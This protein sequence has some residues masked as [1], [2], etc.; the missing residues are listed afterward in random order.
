MRDILAQAISRHQAG[1][2][3]AAARS[4]QKVLKAAP[5]HA[6]ARHLFGILRFQQGKAD[7]AIKHL[8]AALSARPDYPEALYNL[9]NI[10]SQLGRYAEAVEIY[11]RALAING[12]LVEAHANRGNALLE[13][14][15]YEEA[16]ASFDRALA[17]DAKMV[18]V[19][20]NRG[21]VLRLLKR[22]EEA[23]TSYDHALA[24]APHLVEAHISK[25]DAFNEWGRYAD[26]LAVY[27]K[28]LAFQPGNRQAMRGRADAALNLCDWKRTSE[29]SAHI[30]QRVSAFNPFTFLCYR[31]DPALQRLCSESDVKERLPLMPA[32]LPPRRKWPDDKITIAYL[33][34]DYRQHP[35]AYLMAELFEAHHRDRFHVI[36]MSYG[37]DDSSDMRRRMEKA[38][39]EFH[40]VRN[41]TDEDIARLIHERGVGIAVDIMGYTRDGRPDILAWRPSPVQV[42]YLGYTGTLGTNYIDYLIADPVVT[43]A[44]CEPHYLEKI[45]RLPDCYLVTDRT[46]VT[47]P[48][49]PSREEMGLPKDGFVFCCFNSIHKIRPE[50]FDIWARLLKAVPGSVLWLLSGSLDANANVLQE[51]QARGIEPSRVIFAKWA[52]PEDH[53]ARHRLADLFLDTLPYNAHTTATDALW[54]GLPLLTCQGRSFPA[55]VASSVL[56]ALNMPELI[57]HSLEDYE[58]RALQ[59]AREPER[60]AAVRRK[61]EA[62]RDTAPMFD[63]ERFVRHIETAYAQMWDIFRRGEAPRAFDIPPA[64]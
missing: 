5:T 60:V 19:L 21:T 35:V 28:V 43:P 64:S 22:F 48:Q 56:S 45:V 38:F 42:S 46:R 61:L 30:E 59:F 11:D 33:S 12:G 23:V 24:L 31:D 62:N 49:V 63:T 37:P 10:Y 39:D 57:A 36:A 4:Y 54:V 53:L 2:L 14:R 44:G 16:L 17:I 52:R 58:A 34:N 6:E 13:L 27:E 26:A 18:A 15:R 8:R 25:A 51:A 40:D 1:E 55:R 47:S 9:A 3:E 41:R 20:N 29:I 32:P 50:M 7:E